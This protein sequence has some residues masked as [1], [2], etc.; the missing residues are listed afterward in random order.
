MDP[1]LTQTDE[2]LAKMVQA[3]DI[4]RFGELVERYEKKL[5]RYGR[6][7]LSNSNNLEDIVQEVFLKAYRN[8]Q[9]FDASKKF[10]SWIYRIAHN[11]FINELK[12]SSRTQLSFLEPDLLALHASPENIHSDLE[13]REVNAMLEKTIGSLEQKYKEVLILYYQEDFSYKQI[14]DIL[15]IPIPTVGIRLSRGKQKLREQYNKFDSKHG[16]T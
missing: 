1:L 10:S 7:F 6:K 9:G 15:K 5:L 2:D 14:A 11:E 4:E 8:I 12:K 13:K 16:P 3:G